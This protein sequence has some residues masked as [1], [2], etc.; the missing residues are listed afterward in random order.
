M[1]TSR[2]RLNWGLAVGI[3]LIVLVAI[4]VLA[5]MAFAQKAESEDRVRPVGT[6]ETDWKNLGLEEGTVLAL[7]QE[8]EYVCYQLGGL[9]VYHQGTYT[10]D[11]QVFT[12]RDDAGP[13]RIGVWSDQ[14]LYL[15]RDSA[16]EGIF[17][18][19]DNVP[20]YTNEAMNATRAQ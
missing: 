10:V 6:Y 11:G 17:L 7:G 18:K 16:V 9:E 4:L 2:S 13:T 8:G 20:T 15:I 5:R 3:G 19:K 1:E 12:L 14:T